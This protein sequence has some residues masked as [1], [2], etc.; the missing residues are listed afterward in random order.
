MTEC[1]RDLL[2]ILIGSFISVISGIATFYF[3]GDSD[4]MDEKPPVHQPQPKEDNAWGNAAERNQKPG[5]GQGPVIGLGP[6]RCDD[7]CKLWWGP[8][9]GPRCCCR[10]NAGQL[11]Q[12]GK[13][14][15]W[16]KRYRSALNA[17]A[18]RVRVTIIFWR[19]KVGKLK[20]SPGNPYREKRKEKNRLKDKTN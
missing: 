2:N 15:L 1:S 10:C 3:N 9:E 19:K 12:V 17:T 14:T 4:L 6:C 20:K 18:I 7:R 16:I 8:E 11:I 13:G 5:N